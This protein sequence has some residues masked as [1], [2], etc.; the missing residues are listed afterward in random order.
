VEAG[1]GIIVAADT[2]IPVMAQEFADQTAV[3]LTDGFVPICSA[4]LR[5]FPESTTKAILG[6]FA[7]DRPLTFP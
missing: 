2:I 5:N 6:S 4:P 7:F 1:E 3:L